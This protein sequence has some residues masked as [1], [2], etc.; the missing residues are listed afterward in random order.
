MSQGRVLRASCIHKLLLIIYLSVPIFGL[1]SS[2][3]NV[4][5]K[6]QFAA[7]NTGLLK[8][9]HAYGA[10]VGNSAAET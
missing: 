7:P 10:V 3:R 9:W 5:I 4:I 6:N 8:V 1:L 2:R